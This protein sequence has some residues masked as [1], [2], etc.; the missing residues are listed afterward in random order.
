MGDKLKIPNRRPDCD[1][2]LLKN[3]AFSEIAACSDRWFRT[4][5]EESLDLAFA[6]LNAPV[7]F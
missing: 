5:F 6:I 7:K 1:S 4:L 2:E 3:A